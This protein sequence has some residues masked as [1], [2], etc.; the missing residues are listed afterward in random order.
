MSN[1]DLRD[2]LR[3]ALK[4]VDRSH[5]AALKSGKSRLSATQITV[6]R[7]VQHRDKCQAEIVAETGVDYS[8][9]SDVVARLCGLGI[10]DRYR[11]MSDLR[12]DRVFLTP[13][14]LRDL[15]IAIKCIDEAEKG[16]PRS[17]RDATHRSSRA[18]IECL[19]GR[20][21]AI[22]SRYEKAAAE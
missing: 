11:C 1:L 10:M 17:V 9:V 13:V 15:A 16:V 18:V 21:E 14:G 20:I 3:L 19:N 22:N 4:A 8:T 12:S 2:N 7:A 6:M 5:A